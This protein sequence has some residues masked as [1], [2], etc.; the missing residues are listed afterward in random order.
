MSRNPDVSEGHHIDSRKY[1]AYIETLGRI[2]ATQFG[3]MGEHII[4]DSAIL[5]NASANAATKSQAGVRGHANAILGGNTNMSDN[6]ATIT[7]FGWKAQ[8]KSM[9]MFAGEAEANGVIQRFNA[10]SAGQQQDV[11]NFLRSL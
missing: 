8:N 5:A 11:L 1:R 7:R 3:S 4:F 6:D 10:L 2:C 9:L